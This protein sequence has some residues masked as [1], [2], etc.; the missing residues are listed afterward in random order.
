M[1]AATHASAA[2]RSPALAANTATS[3][4]APDAAISA[5]AASSCSCLR[6]LI[7][8]L[9]PDAANCAAIALPMP[10][11]APVTSAVL[12]ASEISI[13]CERNRAGGGQLGSELGSAPPLRRPAARR[14]RTR[15]DADT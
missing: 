5:A 3:P 9:A 6:E 4:G 1:V 7:I 2:S 8:T 15:E 11:D 12:P 14:A 10:F 13:G